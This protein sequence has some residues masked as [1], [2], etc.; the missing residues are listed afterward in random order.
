MN[1]TTSLKKRN[2]VR[3]D[4]HIASLNFVV[5]DR[6]VRSKIRLCSGTMKRFPIILPS[7]QHV[8][9]PINRFLHEI[10][11][12]V[13]IQQVL[14]ATQERYWIVTGHSVVKKVLKCCIMCKIQH[15][16]LCTQQMA[17]LLEEQMSPDKPPFSFVRIDYFSLL[18]VKAGRTH[19][20][21]YRCVFTCLTTRAVHLEVAQSLTADSFITGFQ[22]FSA[23][24]GVPERVYSDNGTNLVKGDKDL[25]KSIQQWNTSVKEPFKTLK[26]IIINIYVFCMRYSQ[27]NTRITITH[28]CFIASTL[29]GSLGRCLYTRPIGLVFKQL[30]LT[31]QMLMHEKT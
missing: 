31:R 10:N 14:A 9:T 12:H 30:P 13:G 25:R 29:A 17:P 20:K 26:M 11:G 28:V 15:A 6:L 23:R 7:G 24:R 19:L 18:I 5:V 1:K 27:H 22:C 3:K 8:T 4:S 2:L 16:P 21:R